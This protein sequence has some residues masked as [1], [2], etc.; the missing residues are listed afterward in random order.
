M[1]VDVDVEG[2]PDS[3][4]IPAGK[5]AVRI[6]A[7]SDVAEDKRGEEYVKLTYTVTEGDYVNRK[8][9]DNYVRLSGSS[10]LKRILRA[11][12]FSKP[13]LSDTNDMIGLELIVMTK[14]QHDDNFGDQSRVS[15]YLPK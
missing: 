12:K 3:D 6:D 8:L 4:T 5:Y 7:A 15:A 9:Y 13:R 14:I 10:Q 2:L 1:L 11:G